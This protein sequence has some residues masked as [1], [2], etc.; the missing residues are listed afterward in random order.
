MKMQTSIRSIAAGTAGVLA[1]TGMAAAE[2]HSDA[3][4]PGSNVTLAPQT[5]EFIDSLEG[6]EPIYKL[7]PEDARQR[8]I[9]AQT[10][11]AELPAASVEEKTLEV[12][13]TGEVKVYIVRPEGTEGEALPGVVYFHGGGWI[14]GNFTT[15][16]RLIRELANET[17][18]AYVF[19][20]YAPAPEQ[21]HPVQIEQDYAVLDYVAKNADEFGIDAERLATAGDSVGG[22]MVASVAMM[23]QQNGGPEIDAQVMFYPVT[24]AEL[25]S[26]SYDAFADGPWLSKKAMEWFWDAYL[27]EGADASDP[28]ISP[29]N[30]SSEQLAK[31][32]PT[33][34]ITDENDVLRDEGE[35]FAGKLVEA[36]VE[37]ETTRYLHTIHDFVMLNAITETPAPRAAIEQA[38]GFLKAHLAEDGQSAGGKEA[39]G[40]PADQ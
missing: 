18:A 36:G 10:D 39:E 24:T 21:K 20:E 33:L 11:S 22:Q 35:A 16:E 1:L 31:F 29:L 30:A 28:M 26:P 34:V 9:D 5:Q 25:D 40:E 2:K 7:S 3:M 23:A 6:T 4:T 8:L 12:G 15:H 32:A 17:E 14:L 13:P 27:P 19:V 38:A 37:T